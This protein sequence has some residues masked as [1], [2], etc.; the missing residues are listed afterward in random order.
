LFD[1]LLSLK[2]LQ[3]TFL[4]L[5]HTKERLKFPSVLEA[6]AKGSTKSKKNIPISLFLRM[7]V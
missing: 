1:P 4:P 3:K 6:Q 2:A 5:L 7:H